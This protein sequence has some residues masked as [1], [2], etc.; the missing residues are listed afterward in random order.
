MRARKP[1]PRTVKRRLSELRT[2]IKT[3]ADPF[4]CYMAQVAENAIIWATEETAGW[5]TPAHDVLSM[6]RILRREVLK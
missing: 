6:A 5:E 4:E 1:S 3:A 2:L